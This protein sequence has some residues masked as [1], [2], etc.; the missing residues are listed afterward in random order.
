M[1]GRDTVLPPARAV[2]PQP[3]R[4]R[5]RPIPVF[6]M[7]AMITDRWHWSLHVSCK[8]SSW[9]KILSATSLNPPVAYYIFHKQ[10]CQRR[11]KGKHHKQL[12]HRATPQIFIGHDLHCFSCFGKYRIPGYEGFARVNNMFVVTS[13]RKQSSPQHIFLVFQQ[14]VYT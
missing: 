10:T 11:E 2:G 3:K 13:R 14:L 5:C 9:W 12:S 7:D 1:V 4:G 8:R 6:I